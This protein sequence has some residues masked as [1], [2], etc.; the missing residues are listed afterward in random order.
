MGFPPG[1]AA[2]ARGSAATALFDQRTHHCP[3]TGVMRFALSAAALESTGGGVTAG[4]RKRGGCGLRPCAPPLLGGRSSVRAAARLGATNHCEDPRGSHRRGV[5][6]PRQKPFNIQLCRRRCPIPQRRTHFSARIFTSSIGLILD[7]GPRFTQLVQQ[8]HCGSA[9]RS[10]NPV[11]EF[12]RR[13]I[14]TRSAAV[15]VLPCSMQS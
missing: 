11:V 10:R 13:V 3:R 5:T 6:W 7:I 1:A 4:D 2:L 9:P 15:T 14:P 8:R 12:D